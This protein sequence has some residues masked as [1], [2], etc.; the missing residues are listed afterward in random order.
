MLALNRAIAGLTLLAALAGC[1]RDAAEL[2]QAD[3]EAVKAQIEKYTQAGLAADWDAWGNTLAPDVIAL[4]PNTPRVN[5]RAAAVAWIKSLPKLTAFKATVDEVSGQGDIAYAH[6][7]YE[8]VMALPDGSTTMDR[9]TF[10]EVHKRQADGTWPY[11]HLMFHSTEPLPA[12][13]PAK[14]P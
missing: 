4:P 2:S 3:K 8:L 13:A 5:G 6:G 7:T 1:T 14:K 9:G 12:A 11:T 10:L